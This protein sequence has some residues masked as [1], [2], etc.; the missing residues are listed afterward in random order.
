MAK[1]GGPSR[2][3][4]AH[5]LALPDIPWNKRS[6]VPI[7]SIVSRMAEIHMEIAD[8]NQSDISEQSV[9]FHTGKNGSGSWALIN[10]EIRMSRAPSSF[11]TAD[12]NKSAAAATFRQEKREHLG[13]GAVLR[14]L[15]S[16]VRRNVLGG[17]STHTLMEHRYVTIL[18]IIADMKVGGKGCRPKH[19]ATPLA[20]ESFCC[21]RVSTL[22]L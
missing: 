10:S 16:C 9:S 20:Y 13:M 2:W 3:F 8:D 15:P 18:F 22:Q 14:F 7:D 21:F 12:M 11:S 4:S 6:L 19:T 1:R 5:N 17:Q